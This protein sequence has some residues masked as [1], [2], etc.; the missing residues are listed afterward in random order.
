MSNH[1]SSE[2]QDNKNGEKALTDGKND[3][4]VSE[5]L[6]KEKQPS[7][8][9]DLSPLHDTQAIGTAGGDQRA[10]KDDPDEGEEVP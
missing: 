7:R 10:R 4:S 3:N 2:G 1:D 9:G 6:K 8:S 5:A